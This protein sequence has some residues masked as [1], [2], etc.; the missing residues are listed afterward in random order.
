MTRRLA[1]LLPALLVLVFSASTA[2]ADSSHTPRCRF[3]YTNSEPEN[4]NWDRMD[5]ILAGVSG[6]CPTTTTTT[7]STTTTTTTSTT[8]TTL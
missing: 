4:Q 3:N 1:W 5:K 6:A 2:S 7:S 8:T